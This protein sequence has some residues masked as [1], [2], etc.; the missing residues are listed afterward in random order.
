MDRK[1][2]EMNKEWQ[3]I[4]LS[5]KGVGKKERNTIAAVQRSRVSRR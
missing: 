2:G 1:K 4:E 5:K 3:K